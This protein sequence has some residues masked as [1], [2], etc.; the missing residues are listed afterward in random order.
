MLSH[1]LL[2]D[3]FVSVASGYSTGDAGVDAL[4]FFVSGESMGGLLALLAGI[5]LAACRRMEEV[6]TSHLTLNFPPN[7]KRSSLPT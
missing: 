3:D 7:C 1:K 2:V 6:S 4:P 5:E